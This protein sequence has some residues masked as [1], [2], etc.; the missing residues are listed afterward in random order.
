VAVFG[1]AFASLLMMGAFCCGRDVRRKD[2]PFRRHLTKRSVAPMMLQKPP[3]A[4]EKSKE[5]KRFARAD[6]NDDGKIVLAPMP[7]RRPAHSSRI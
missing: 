3:A 4:T 6:R 1:R 5:E 2:R 7:S